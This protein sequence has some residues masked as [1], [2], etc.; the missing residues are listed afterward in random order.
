MEKNYYLIIDLEAT[1]CDNK[2]FPR[3]ETE[4]I[5]IGAV[6][7]DL[8]YNILQEKCI[9]IKPT[10]HQITPF[11]TQ[12][13]SITQDMVDNGISLEEGLKIVKDEMWTPDTLFCSWGFYDRNQIK[14]EKKKKGLEYPFDDQHRNIKLDVK[15]KLGL[16][17]KEPLPS[18]MKRLGVQFEGT[19][20][21]GID[22]ARNMAIILKKVYCKEDVQ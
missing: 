14:M 8:E 4:I 19:P 15:E 11:C 18:V 13:T 20:H 10:K 16:A 3:D 5:E 9:M 2:E 17:K 21:R 1:C 12:L 6:K 22:D 7:T